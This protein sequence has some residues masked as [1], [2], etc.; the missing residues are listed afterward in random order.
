MEP[1]VEQELQEI[2]GY[3]SRFEDAHR[4]YVFFIGGALVCTGGLPILVFA[5]W[6][7]GSGSIGGAV[8][9]GAAFVAGLFAIGV[10]WRV[11][12]HR[13]FREIKS[14]CLKLR[15]AGYVV[16]KKPDFLRNVIGATRDLSE[17]DIEPLDFESI[18]PSELHY[19]M[20]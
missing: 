20:I 19:K 9:M 12:L 17:S 15:R 16:Y 14:R 3:L 5:H 13:M 6:L 2:N 8:L 7:I 11:R 4:T 18:E 1:L 10:G